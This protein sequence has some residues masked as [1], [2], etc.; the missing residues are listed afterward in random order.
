MIL[1]YVL[2]KGGLSMCT[3]FIW[4]SAGSSSTVNRRNNM[5]N[6]RRHRIL[7]SNKCYFSLNTVLK[8]KNIF[9]AAKCKLYKTVGYCAETCVVNKSV[10]KTLMTFERKMLRKT[11]GPMLEDNQWRKKRTLN[12]K[13]CT[14]T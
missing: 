11:F 12:L 3:G 1:Q 2:K 10:K 8:S 14:R 13:N 5:S 4:S 9:G 7:L 6:E